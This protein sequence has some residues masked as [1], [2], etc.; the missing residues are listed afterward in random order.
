[1]TVIVWHYVDNCSYFHNVLNQNSYILHLLNVLHGVMCSSTSGLKPLTSWSFSWLPGNR[2]PSV[3]RLWAKLSQLAAGSS[4]IFTRRTWEWYPSSCL[5]KKSQLLYVFKAANKPWNPQMECVVYGGITNSKQS[6]RCW[7][8][9]MPTLSWSDTSYT[10]VCS[11]G[12][13]VKGLIAGSVCEV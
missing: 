12:A 13:G 5:I 4:N 3:S 9:H 10:S 2:F 7:F 8:E 6:G 1:M 11:R